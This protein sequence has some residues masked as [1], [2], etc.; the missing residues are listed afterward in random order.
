MPSCE[1]TEKVH[2]RLLSSSRPK[3]LEGMA[4][5]TTAYS[6][7]SRFGKFT[8]PLLR[9]TTVRIGVMPQQEPAV[10]GMPVCVWPLS[11]LVHW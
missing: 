2:Q 4:D 7:V 1:S 11:V 3:G 9:L 6:P 10:P 5:S 8:A